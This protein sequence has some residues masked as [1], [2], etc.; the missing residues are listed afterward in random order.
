MT[1]VLIIDQ[2]E[3]KDLATI[4]KNLKDGEQ[5][6]VELFRNQEG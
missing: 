3:L 1:D 2:K 6:T 4:S 5:A